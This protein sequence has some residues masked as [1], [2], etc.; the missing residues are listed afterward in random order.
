VFPHAPLQS[1]RFSPH[2][3]YTHDCSVAMLQARGSGSCSSSALSGPVT[4]SRQ[5]TASASTARRSV[6][7]AM[8][9]SDK[10][11]GRASAPFPEGSAAGATAAGV[12]TGPALGAA[13]ARGATGGAGLVLRP[14]SWDTGLH[15][16]PAMVKNLIAAR[17]GW[18]NHDVILNAGP[19]ITYLAI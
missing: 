14:C 5:S 13:A 1:S 7:D 18:H 11:R 8:V 17:E 9:L 15:P 19:L 2:G 3:S 6:H 12:V 10:I 4:L 16:K